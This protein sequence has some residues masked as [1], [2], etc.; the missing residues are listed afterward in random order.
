LIQVLASVEVERQP[1][2][3]RANA[4]V[5]ASACVGAKGTSTCRVMAADGVLFML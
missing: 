2:I 1:G 5:K 3:S 4:G